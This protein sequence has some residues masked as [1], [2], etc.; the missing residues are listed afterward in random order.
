MQI[1]AGVVNPTNLA[2]AG[3]I[4]FDA[5]NEFHGLRNVGPNHATYFVL[6]FSPHDLLK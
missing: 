1:V 2:T 4:I 6:K 3:G 5:S